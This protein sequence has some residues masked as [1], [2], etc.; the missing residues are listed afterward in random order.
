RRLC[1]I[2]ALARFGP[3]PSLRSA[4]SKLRLVGETTSVHALDDDRG[5]HAAAGAHRDEAALQ[6]AAL[7]LVEHR[8]DQHRTGGADRMAERHGAAVHVDLLAVELEVTDELLRHHGECL[9][10]LEEV[11]VLEL[12]A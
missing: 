5:G 10:D 11:D 3:P 8:A 12:E 2:Q 7:E 1:G 4:P 6:V 9:V